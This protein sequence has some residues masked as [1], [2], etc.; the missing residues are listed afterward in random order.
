VSLYT[1]SQD[2][3]ALDNAGPDNALVV[4][5]GDG[6]F[7]V[8]AQLGVIPERTADLMRLFGQLGR[9]T[10][11]PIRTTAIRGTTVVVWDSPEGAPRAESRVYWFRDDVGYALTAAGHSSERLLTIAE[12]MLR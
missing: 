10:R 3:G 11:G 9:D 6:L 12:S 5:Y 8:E 4:V 7:L 2:R 1:L